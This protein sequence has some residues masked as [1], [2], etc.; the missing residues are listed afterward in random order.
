MTAH[1]SLTLHRLRYPYPSPAGLH[2]HTPVCVALHLW[3]LTFRIYLA[4]LHSHL[5][6]PI[7]HP[8]IRPSRSDKYVTHRSI[9]PWR[10]TNQPTTFLGGQ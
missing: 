4:L 3:P 10:P 8:L 2:T 7:N 9:A 1:L 6:Q 5:T